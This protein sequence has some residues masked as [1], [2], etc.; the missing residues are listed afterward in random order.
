MNIKDNEMFTEFLICPLC[1]SDLEIDGTSS[2]ICKKCGEKYQIKDGIPIMLPS[3]TEIID[4]KFV[5]FVEELGSIQSYRDS[6]IWIWKQEDGFLRKNL[7]I[8]N[9][10]IIDAGGGG[11][12]YRK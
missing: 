8:E 1:H 6:S 2:L 3:P 12:L 4:K 9:K 5:E 11:W 7:D 10:I